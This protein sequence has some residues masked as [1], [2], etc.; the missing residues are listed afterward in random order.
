MAASNVLNITA[1][2]FASEV[3][4]SP[5][6]VLIDFWAEWCGP[7]KAVAPII[8]ELAAELDGRAK[9]GKINIDE[10]SAL[11]GQ[12]GGAGHSDD[13]DPQGRPSHGTGRGPPQQTRPE[14][15]S[16]KVFGG[17][18]SRKSNPVRAAG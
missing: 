6:P 16:R 1:A 18:V 13:P 9:F 5:I 11:A 14:A 7:C 17:N 3:L 12:Y 4:Q 15:K 8:D 2:N 10:Q